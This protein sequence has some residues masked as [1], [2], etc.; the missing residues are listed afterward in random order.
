MQDVR[1]INWKNY[2]MNHAYGVKHY[3]LKEESVVP[4]MGYSDAL[5]RMNLAGW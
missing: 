3:L 2:V 4:S 1:G 5:V